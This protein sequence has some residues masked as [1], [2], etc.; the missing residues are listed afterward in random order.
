MGTRNLTMVIDKMGDLKVAQYGQWDGYPEGQG[1]TILNFCRNTINLEE[2]EK[3]LE[4]C[5]FYNRCNDIE[6]WLNVADELLN[7]DGDTIAVERANIWFNQT[8]TRDLGGKILEKLIKI[9]L[10]YLPEE[11]KNH[12]YLYDE[13]DFG[14]DS[15]MC[16][17]AY[18]V[19]FQTKKLMVFEG[20]NKDKSKEYEWFKT[21]QKEVDERYSY[22]NDRWYGCKLIKEYDLYKLPTPEEFVKELRELTKGEDEDE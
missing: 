17:W 5:R 13:F 21:D 8:K 14:K 3:R 12:I 11:H 4:I 15:L 10:S 1:T 18:C 7:G 6:D 2:L 20:F 9:N 22:T 16:E 19:N